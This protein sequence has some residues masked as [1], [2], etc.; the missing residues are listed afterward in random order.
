MWNVFVSIFRCPIPIQCTYFMFGA[1]PNK[2]IGLEPYRYRWQKE[3]K[4]RLPCCSRP[5]WTGSI[6]F[7]SGLWRLWAGGDFHMFQ[8]CSGCIQILKMEMVGKGCDKKEGRGG[9][10]S[11]LCCRNFDL[12][13]RK[14]F[15]I[16]TN[17]HTI[18]RSFFMTHHNKYTVQLLH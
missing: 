11:K 18:R 10:G 14:G 7:W 4:S 17:I 1:W 6:A 8:M 13:F 5:I 2:H 3:W 16:Q 9:L 12:S 15:P